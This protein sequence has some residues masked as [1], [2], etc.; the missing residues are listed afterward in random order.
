MRLHRTSLT[1]IETRVSIGQRQNSID[2]AIDPMCGLIE[3]RQEYKSWDNV[4]RI[5]E[6]DQLQR[7]VC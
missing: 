7:I 4:R 3:R 2:S 6:F 1:S 5:Y